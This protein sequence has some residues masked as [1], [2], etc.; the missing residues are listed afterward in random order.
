MTTAVKSTLGGPVTIAVT[1]AVKPGH[2][3]EFAEALHRFAEATL[4]LPGQ[5]GLHILR[6]PR[7]STE[8][9]YGILRTFENEA[10]FEAFSRTPVFNQWH[11]K[12]APWVEGEAEVRHIP[13]VEAWFLPAK[14]SG[15]AGPPKWRL[16]L[17]TYLA[18]NLVTTP[19]LWLVMPLIGAR[20]AFPWDNFL[21]NLPVV[22]LLTWIVMPFLGSVF[23]NQLHAK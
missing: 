8:R 1:R 15:G 3:A 5:L 21:F 10:A 11:E 7:G 17:L 16:A 6:P 12:I 19:M 20:A 22:A 14:A 18:V 2:E 9:S 4:R 13:G 23:K